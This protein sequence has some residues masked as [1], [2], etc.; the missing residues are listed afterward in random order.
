[1]SP[2]MTFLSFMMGFSLG[3]FS[4]IIVKSI[5]QKKKSALILLFN[6]FTNTL[7]GSK[8]YTKSNTS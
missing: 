3:Y 4:T 7:V 1:M 8:V 6:K 5:L 2:K